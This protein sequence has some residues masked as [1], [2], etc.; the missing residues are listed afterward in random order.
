[1]LLTFAAGSMGIL[2]GMRF[3]VPALVAA[4]V[5][6]AAMCLLIAPF[7]ELSADAAAGTMLAL[8]TALQGGYLVGLVISAAWSRVGFVLAG[9]GDG[10]HSG[11]R[12][13]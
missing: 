12:T 7:T 1:M 3:R 5:T 9:G 11:M 8:L 4:S 6:T 13:R 10:A 2:L